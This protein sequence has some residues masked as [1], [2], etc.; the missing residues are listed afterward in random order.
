MKFSTEITSTLALLVF[1]Y[2]TAYY[3]YTRYFSRG[4]LPKHLPWVGVDNGF[5]S[6]PRATLNSVLHT[7]ELLLEGYNKV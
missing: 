2:C 4:G 7:R 5:F 1:T 6:R 3:F